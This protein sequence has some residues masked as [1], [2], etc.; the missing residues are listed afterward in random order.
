MGIKVEDI[1]DYVYK[2]NIP[3]NARVIYQRIED[4]YFDGIDI[5]GMICGDDKIAIDDKYP[6]G[7]KAEPWETIKIKGESY[8]SAVN[9]NKQVE[10]AKL[11]KEGKIDKDEIGP[12]FLRDDVKEIDLND[13]KLKDQYVESETIFYNKDNN[14]LC[15]SAHI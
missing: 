11:V 12:Y 3:R 15:I 13:D 14:V 10:K 4:S 6:P 2:K 9:Y 1:L 5:S 8:Y 7:S